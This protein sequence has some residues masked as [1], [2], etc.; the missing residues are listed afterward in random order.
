M[1]HLEWTLLFVGVASA[2]LT[3]VAGL[4]D[5]SRAA[6][7]LVPW[8]AAHAF[9]LLGVWLVLRRGARLRLPLL[10]AIGLLPRLVLLPLEPKLSEDVYRYLWDGRLV[11]E[12]VNPFPHAPADPSLARYH[13]ALLARLNHAEVPTIY[14]PLAQFLFGATARLAA[15]PWAW[16]TT[17]LGLEAI[18]LLALASLLRARGLPAE[19]LLLYFWN[20]LVIV[21]SFGSGHVDLAAAAFL[22]FAFALHE[23]GRNRLSGALFASAVLV[24]YMPL[25]LVPTL[26]RRRAFGMLAVAAI[27]IA[28]FFVP[29]LSAGS[30]LWTGLATY[31]RHWE[32]NGPLYAI[33]RPFFLTGEPPRFILAALLAVATGVVAWRAKTLTGAAL[34]LL[35]VWILVSPTVYPWYLLLLVA[36]LP[37]HADAGIL[38]FSGLVAL[39]YA[40]LGAS[41]VTGVWELPGWIPWVE[42]GGW[43]AAS[44]GAALLLRATRYRR[45]AA[46]ATESTPT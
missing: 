7:L 17:L 29:F 39:S 9:Y 31:L 35:A 44:I 2:A 25:L 18:L 46:C 10:L 34:L 16:K 4:A 13:D 30:A 12:G 11:S 28:A 40:G 3:A 41:R 5:G 27:V 43:A 8:L 45:A 6:Q 37:L 21:E 23:R 32:F 20:P 33:L 19:R 26:L 24:K 38:L 1:S 36:L 14:P 15:E 42:Y 22:L